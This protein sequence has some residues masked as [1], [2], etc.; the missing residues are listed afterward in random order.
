MT[1]ETQERDQSLDIDDGWSG[2]SETEI[3][4]DWVYGAVGVLFLAGVLGL[5]VGYLVGEVG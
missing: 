2:D 3:W 5:V 4:L 1:Q